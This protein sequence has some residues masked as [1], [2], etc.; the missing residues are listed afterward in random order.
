MKM[1]NSKNTIIIGKK[2]RKRQGR[3]LQATAMH[4]FLLCHE[5]LIK[6]FTTKLMLHV[7]TKV[8]LRIVLILTPHK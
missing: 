6:I 5:D 8:G 4:Y 3:I 2:E 7:N 1:L